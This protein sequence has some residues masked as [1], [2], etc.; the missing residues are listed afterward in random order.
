MVDKF[1]FVNTPTSY[2]FRLEPELV[3][4]WL[5]VKADLPETMRITI[6]AEVI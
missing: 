4:W 3:D 2:S 6:D 1:G 5:R